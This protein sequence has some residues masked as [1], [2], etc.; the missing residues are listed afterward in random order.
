MNAFFDFAG[1]V[2]RVVGRGAF[3]HEFAWLIDNPV[4]RLFVTPETLVRRLDLPPSADVLE[5]GPGSGFFTLSLAGAARGVTVTDTQ[6]E[7]LQLTR[8][9][10]T[11]AGISNI[12]YVAANASGQLPFHGE[13]FDAAVL[14]TVL[15]DVPQ[16]DA[17]LREL[18]RIPRPRGWVAI[19]EHLPEIRIS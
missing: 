8:K 10:A 11:S 18:H 14:V 4:R 17:C 3:P 6:P 19:H 9:K 5:I 12:R 13:T 2:R 16:P 15:G 7:M 1:R